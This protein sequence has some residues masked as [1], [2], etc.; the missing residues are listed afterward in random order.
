MLIYK[1]SCIIFQAVY[2]RE[3][4]V[5]HMV[6]VNP[7]LNKSPRLN[8]EMENLRNHVMKMGGFVEQ[9]IRRAADAL[10]KLD[11]DEADTVY[12]ER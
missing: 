8:E 11:I 3:L 5:S 2:K 12:P 4:M 10:R 7:N 6:S 9:Q 1:Q